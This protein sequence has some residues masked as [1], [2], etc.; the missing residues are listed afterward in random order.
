MVKL[1]VSP[2]YD[3]RP[4]PMMHSLPEA[5]PLERAIKSHPSQ[6]AGRRATAL[7]YISP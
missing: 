4:K 1:K 3:E 5:G 7:D 2:D 6:E